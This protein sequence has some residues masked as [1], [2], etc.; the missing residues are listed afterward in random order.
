M[1]SISEYS[2]ARGTDE[3]WDKIFDGFLNSVYRG[4]GACGTQDIDG[5]NKAFAELR[6]FNSEGHKA[7]K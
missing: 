7:H 2:P 5:L 3:S 6:A 4:I 1:I